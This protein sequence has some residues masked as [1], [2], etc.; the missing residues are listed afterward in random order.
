MTPP[1]YSEL[2]TTWHRQPITKPKLMLGIPSAE[3]LL[4]RNGP[5]QVTMWR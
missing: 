5:P 1:D 3:S 2:S 4:L